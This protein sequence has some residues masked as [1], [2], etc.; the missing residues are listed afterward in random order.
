[1]RKITCWLTLLF[2]SL[3]AISQKI[4][5]V[6]TAK[7]SPFFTRL[8]QTKSKIQPLRESDFPFLN[9][10]SPILKSR[11]Y[12]F[13][14]LNGEIFVY[15]NAS[16][17]VYKLQ[18][19]HRSDSLLYFKRIDDTENFNYNIDAFLFT[20]KNDIYNLGGYGFWRTTGTLRKFNFKDKEWDAEP[21]NREIHLPHLDE[22]KFTGHLSWFNNHSGSIYI[23]FQRIINTS[24][25]TDKDIID[26]HVFK[27]SLKDKN[28]EEMGKTDD[29]YYKIIS[30]TKWNLAT[31]FGQL[32][33]LYQKVYLVN[34]EEN[35][36]KEL[37]D[38]SLEQSLARV[39]N[40]SLV[41][42]DNKTVYYLNGKTG[43]YDSVK[44]PLNSFQPAEFAIWR[45]K[46]SFLPFMVPIV[47]LAGTAAARRRKNTKEKKVAEEISVAI[48]KSDNSAQFNGNGSLKPII[49]FS[50][51]EKQ[52]LQ[53][54]L[55]KSKRKETTTISEI[56]YVLGIKDKNIGL[57]KK[58]RSEVLNSINEKFGFLYS[59]EES[60][61][62][63]SRS[64]ED[65]RY[66]EYYIDEKNFSLI[67]TVLNEEV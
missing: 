10:E 44:V 17:L 66:F 12:H 51:T 16:G 37:A 55:E 14:P 52:L 1:M 25:K 36:V 28:W 38:P 42:Y 60:L 59:N 30:K 64:Q 45:K 47:L 35:T 34:F 19:D 54:L 61:I 32:I 57:Q 8:L 53:L 23:P 13:F 22:M 11:K 48:S 50:E 6:I 2:I 3:G 21:I 7:N 27:M 63:N 20:S 65:K 43:N 26:Q 56:N 41:Y 15:F 29:E 40:L 62:A 24:L 31:D 46:T 5:S 39:N 49:R 67:E 58:V 33:C 9:L 4:D 18:K